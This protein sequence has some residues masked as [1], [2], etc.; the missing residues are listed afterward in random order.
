MDSTHVMNEA[1]NMATVTGTINTVDKAKRIANISRG[2]IKKWNRGPATMDFVFAE[3]IDLTGLV[4]QQQL[5][6]TFSVQAG[7]F[8][9]QRIDIASS[10]QTHS[11]H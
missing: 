11:G 3:N 7:E 8:I 5:T 4:P 6:F 10:M 9:I 1:D 2:A